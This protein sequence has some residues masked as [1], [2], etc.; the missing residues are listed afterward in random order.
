M[1]TL[2]TEDDGVVKEI[3]VL[4]D[5]EGLLD[6]TVLPNF[7]RLGRRLRNKVPRVKELLAAA[8][9]SAVRR[10]LE[11]DGRYTLD[12]DGEPVELEPDDVVIRAA[13]LALMRRYHPDRNGSAEAAARARAVTEAY[14]TIGN[15]ASRAL[16]GARF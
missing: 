14:K 15:P 3:V 16:F 4:T 13:Y 1:D 5:L 12:V 9:G 11:T 6:V 8:D 2:L 10:A 7:E